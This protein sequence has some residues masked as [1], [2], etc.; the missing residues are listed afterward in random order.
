MQMII[1]MFVASFFLATTFMQK[2]YNQKVEQKKIHFVDLN[3]TTKR[4][5]GIEKVSIQYKLQDIKDNPTKQKELVEKILIRTCNNIY[6]KGTWYRCSDAQKAHT[7]W[8][9]VG[10][11]GTKGD[12]DDAW[13]DSSTTDT[14]ACGKEKEYGR[15]LVQASLPKQIIN[16]DNWNYTLED[17]EDN[18]SYPCGYSEIVFM[19]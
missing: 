19:K 18:S 1:I 13:T 16:M 5:Q 3:T 15:Y 8:K 6:Q 4:L 12:L 11:I 14:F 9:F 7:V 17:V 10:D 2:I